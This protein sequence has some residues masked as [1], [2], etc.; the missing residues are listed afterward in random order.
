MNIHSRISSVLHA[1]FLDES[2]TGIPAFD[3]SKLSLSVLPKFSI[4]KNLR[5]GHLVESVVQDLIKSS[6]NYRLLNDNIQLIESGKTLGEIDF[7]IQEKASKQITHLEL[8]YKFYLFDPSISEKS[9]NNWIGPNRNDSLQ[10]KLEKLRIKQFPLLYHKAMANQLAPLDIQ[11]MNQKLCFLVSLFVP[12]QQR[13]KF[14]PSLKNAVKGYYLNYQ[15]FAQ[16]DHSAKV[17]HLPEK[18]MWGVHPSQN[19]EWF[20]FAELIHELEN[21]MENKKAPMCWG[22]NDDKFNSFFIV[23]W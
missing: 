1:N 6:S 13:I 23:W 18:K 9:I 20:D 3:L 19:Q 2:F 16:M 22:K 8:A 12:Y 21:Q 15:Q 10:E 14:N 11:T 7:I 4:P 5:L 17:Y